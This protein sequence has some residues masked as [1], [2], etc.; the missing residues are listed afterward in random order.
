MTKPYFPN[1]IKEIEQQE[2]ENIEYEKKLNDRITKKIRFNE[3]IPNWIEKGK[4]LIYPEKYEKWEYYVTNIARE[5][6]EGVSFNSILDIMQLIEECDCVDEA[7]IKLEEQGLLK[8]L[9]ITIR[10]IILKFSNKG[11]KFY[12]ALLPKPFNTN[13]IERLEK[14][15]T[16]NS[17]F[18]KN[19]TNINLIKK[20]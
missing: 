2:A 18:A 1:T 17:E 3:K 9:N 6:Y 13:I 20:L 12:K 7:L 19:N 5:T 16:E 15:E 4:N 10:E 11:P 8:K 14:Q